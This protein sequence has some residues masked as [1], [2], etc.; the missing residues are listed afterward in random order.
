MIDN[1][2]QFAGNLGKDA[3]MRYTPSGTPVTNTSLAVQQREGEDPIWFELSFWGKKAE[4]A[5]QHLKKGNRI[6][7]EG[8]FRLEK[9]T[10]RDGTLATSLG[11]DVD[12]WLFMGSKPT[13]N[14]YDLVITG[15]ESFL[16]DGDQ[17]PF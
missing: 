13:E 16:E 4:S 6:I 12:G 3:E 17:I 5:A 10:R 2:V 8:R 1:K 15:N 11:V 9:Y 14:Q 7:V